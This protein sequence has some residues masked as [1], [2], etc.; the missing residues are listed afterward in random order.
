MPWNR[1][2]HSVTYDNQNKIYIYA[3]GLNDSVIANDLFSFDTI[4]QRYTSLSNPGVARFGHTASLLSNGQL[5]ILGGVI[6]TV[7]ENNLPVVFLASMT[8]VHVYDTLTNVWSIINATGAVLPSSRTSHAAVVTSDDKIIIFGGE[9]GAVTRSKAYLNAIAILNTKTWTWLVPPVTGIPPSRRCNAAAGILSNKYL[10]IAFGATMWGYYNDINVLDIQTNS[11]IQ[12][13]TTAEESTGLNL[14]AGEIAGITIASIVLLV[15]ILLLLWKLQGYIRRFFKRIYHYIWKPRI[16]EPVWTETTRIICQFILISIFCLLLTFSLNQAIKSPIVT[17]I[18]Q[19]SVG[20]VQ[21]P[22]IRFCFS[23]FPK[24]TDTNP[25]YLGVTCRNSLGHSCTEFIQEL[26]MSLFKPYY[27]SNLGEVNCYLFR[28][29]D[30]FVLTSTSGINNGSQLLFNF[31]GDERLDYGRIYTTV[32]P[33][34]MNPNTKFYQ[35]NDT[36][37]ALLTSVELYSWGLDEIIDVQMKNRYDIEPFTH[38]LLAYSLVEHRYLQ[39]VNW[40]YVGFLPVVS[41]IPEISSSFRSESTNPNIERLESELGTLAVFPS[42]FVEITEIDVKV[43]TLVNSLGFVGG[44]TGLLFSLQ[45][46]LFG[47]RPKS[48]WGIVHRWSKGIFKRSLLSNLQ[49][50]FKVTDSGVPLVDPVHR[51]LIISTTDFNNLDNEETEAQRVGRVEE[52]VQML[53]TLFKAYYVDD[54]VFRTLSDANRVG[55]VTDGMAN[56]DNDSRVTEMANMA[57][58]SRVTE[59]ANMDNDS[60]RFAPTSTTAPRTDD[61]DESNRSLLKDNNHPLSRRDTS[62]SYI[63]RIP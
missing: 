44:I 5:V 50:K 10:T 37:E 17:Q 29:P 46:C 3:G 28:A 41:S 2:Y 32:Y 23:G 13:F 47:F 45:V 25:R 21:V 54:E 7:D 27:I 35:I 48:P 39:D 33:K 22:D 26:N 63:S 40:N 60:G 20:N 51:R 61:D 43:Y 11:W 58:D 19:K 36:M 31:W 8:Q 15:I 30:G 34:T 57:N 53:E 1:I 14:S 24:Y 62:Q 9:N 18:T 42:A 4:T 6:Y 16:G 52:R 12:S 49:S 55:G 38:S 56:M 59:M